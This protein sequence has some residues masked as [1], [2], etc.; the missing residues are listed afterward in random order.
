MEELNAD[1][2]LPSPDLH[3]REAITSKLGALW[4]IEEQ[5]WH[6]KSRINWLKAG[7]QNTRFFHLTTLHRRQRNI[8]LKIANDDGF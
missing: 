7:D 5:I 3:H 8:I 2:L 1:I 6:Q 4:K